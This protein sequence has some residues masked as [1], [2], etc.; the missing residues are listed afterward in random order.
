MAS[1]EA[2]ILSAIK[3]QGAAQ[4]VALNALAKSSEQT[5]RSMASMNEGMTLLLERQAS[6]PRG[7]GGERMSPVTILTL[8]GAL[9]AFGAFAATS[10]NS[11]VN[12]LRSSIITMTELERVD[13][14]DDAT[15]SAK[16]S[17]SLV[18]I[19]TQFGQVTSS[20]NELS[21]RLKEVEDKDLKHEREVALINTGQ[22]G[23]LEQLH[24]MLCA[25]GSRLVP[26]T[27][28]PD[29]ITQHYIK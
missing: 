10:M 26:A 28:C 3:D 8:M 24:G 14:S 25:L 16:Q 23:G 7:V 13:A 5:A 20:V 4:S 27:T 15:E 11:N 21:L 12:E 29:L 2:E 19:G 18:E 1:M 22:G 9:A 17:A 6:V